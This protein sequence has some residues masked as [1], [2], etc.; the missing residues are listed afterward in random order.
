MQL[1][2][3]LVAVLPSMVAGSISTPTTFEQL[4]SKRMCESFCQTI[5]LSAG[6]HMLWPFTQHQFC[7]PLIKTDALGIRYFENTKISPRVDSWPVLQNTVE[8][9]QLLA[10]AL[11]GRTP[12]AWALLSGKLVLLDTN[13][14]T[15]S[16][17]VT[18]GSLPSGA[19]LNGAAC[20]GAAQGNAVVLVAASARELVALSC[21]DTN[22][23]TC[24]VTKRVMLAPEQ[25]DKVATT[26][27]CDGTMAWVADGRSGCVFSVD[28]LSGTVRKHDRAIAYG[29]VT[30]LAAFR[31]HVAV[32][33]E[34]AVFYDYNPTTG[35]FGR[36]TD[37]GDLIDAPPR[38]LA[39]LGDDL[40]IGHQWCL[41]VIRADTGWVDRVSGAQGLPA[42][43][44]TGLSVGSDANW[45]ILWISTAIGAVRYTPRDHPNDRWRYFSGDRWVVGLGT[46]V[47]SLIVDGAGAWVATGAAGIAHI[48]SWQTTL[49]AKAAAYLHNDVPRLDR[50]GWVAAAG[51]QAYGDVNK[52]H[53]Q[54]GDNDGL[55]TGML[56][57][58]LSF[59]YALTRDESV[60]VAAWRHFS[61]LE[62]LH[63][64][65]LS[66]GFVARTAVRCDEPHQGGDGTICPSGSPDTCGWVNSSQ[67][68]D[69]VDTVDQDC[70]WTWKRDTS[71]DEVDGHV[72]ALSVA[73]DHLATT[74]SERFRIAAPLCR[75]IAHIVDAGFLLIDP[76]TG[77]HTTWGYWD[78]ATLNKVPNPK[79]D[80]GLNSLE[81]LSYLATAARI[82]D[83]N[84]SLS[85]PKQKWKTFGDAFVSL[86]REHYYDANMVNALITSP[87][88]IAFFDY[89]LAFLSYHSL[90]TGAPEI[91]RKNGSGSTPYIP[92]TE[93]EGKTFQRRFQSSLTRYW[94]DAA[95]PIHGREQRVPALSL[96]YTY[97]TGKSGLS[98]PEWQLRRYPDS[99][100]INW[101]TNNTARL[102]VS[103]DREWLRCAEKQVAAHALPADE[104]FNARASDFVTEAST[105]NCDGGGG[106][107]GAAPNPWLLVMW[108]SRFYGNATI[109]Q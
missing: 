57:A 58:A 55:W 101:P 109:Q 99:P 19:A 66:D 11:A 10:S 105:S 72:F 16:V 107:N 68:Y 52:T 88:G 5:A 20:Q 56:V 17:D 60:H 23:A 37:V 102:D 50:Y 82:C 71:S 103:L 35:I 40:W 67:C 90:L 30:A 51:L 18:G 29:N 3:L 32:G 92:L 77:Q 74:R 108:M 26:V 46:A 22:A 84:D 36:H 25:P 61:A 94:T 41:N 87:N 9:P 73:H 95:S 80:R 48:T 49:E 75:M 39:F 85:S 2:V 43:N 28:L 27:A 97:A 96:I 6:V 62:F 34:S 63:N 21:H 42:G 98:D 70:C 59:Q 89:R 4:S 64:V 1:A 104:A 24:T 7:Y 81:I 47:T 91:T 12:T 45:P 38:A 14:H 93:A 76:V 79:G 8:T 33:T 86:V 44:I 15:R 65:T 83:G 69:G 54:D 31:G 100:I 78:P 106:D 53:P 13:G